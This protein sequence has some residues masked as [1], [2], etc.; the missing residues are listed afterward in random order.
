MSWNGLSG[1]R[2][3][4]PP[5][6]PP[7]GCKRRGRAGARCAA[8]GQARKRGH[9]RRAHGD[10]HLRN[11]VLMDGQPVAYDALEFDETLGTC[12][13]LYDLAFLLMDLC[14]RG[15]DRAACRVLDAWLTAFRGTEDGGLAGLLLFMSVRAAI[16]AMVLPQTDA[17]RGNRRKAQPR[18]GFT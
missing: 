3:P 6:T 1:S 15:L 5:E 11:I 13:L 4:K 9:V 18:S 10:L 2:R 8:A 12:D 14:H 7:N 17:A 16:R